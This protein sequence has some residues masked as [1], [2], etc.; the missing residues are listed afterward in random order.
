MDVLLVEVI[1]PST[2]RSYDY[3]IPAKMKSSKVK[4]RIIADIRQFE[5]MPN[6][7]KNEADVQLFCENC[8]IEADKTLSEAGVKSGNTL[9]II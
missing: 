6:I 7:F 2:S 8:C 4:T 3:R 9:M 5:G 1:C